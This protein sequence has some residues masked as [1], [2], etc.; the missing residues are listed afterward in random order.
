MFEE[1]DERSTV[2]CRNFNAI[3]F[4]KLDGVEVAKFVPPIK[5]EIRAFAKFKE[6]VNEWSTA[7][8]NFFETF[9]LFDARFPET[10]ER[11]GK[12][13]APFRVGIEPARTVNI[14]NQADWRAFGDKPDAVVLFRKKRTNSQGEPEA[15][16]NRGDV[17]ESMT[18]VLMNA[19][20]AT[21]KEVEAKDNEE[22]Q[23]GEVKPTR[24]A[25]TENAQGLG[26]DNVP[27][28]DFG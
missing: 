21:H 3:F 23:N 5:D 18:P 12:E 17:A 6:D 22:A 16:E 9:D 14:G 8:R 27:N 20:R 13:I 1:F 11:F 2:F 15:E 25:N 10:N 19:T 28:D 24:N 26:V 4:C 7:N